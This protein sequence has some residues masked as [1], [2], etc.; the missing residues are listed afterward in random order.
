MKWN[1]AGHVE[2][3]RDERWTKR[4]ARMETTYIQGVLEEPGR[5]RQ[6]EMER[7]EGGLGPS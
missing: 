2:I 6:T 7:Y 4:Y 3:Q 1:W 5:P